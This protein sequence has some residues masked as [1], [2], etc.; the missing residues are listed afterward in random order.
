MN[1]SATKYSVD[2]QACDHFSQG[3]PA[4]VQLVVL[5]LQKHTSRLYLLLL[6]VKFNTS[7]Q[8]RILQYLAVNAGRV[9]P[10]LPYRTN[11]APPFLLVVRSVKVRRR[12]RARIPVEKQRV[13][14]M[15]ACF[16]KEDHSSRYG[17]VN[18]LLYTEASFEYS[19]CDSHCRLGF[20]TVAVD[21]SSDSGSHFT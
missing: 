3:A 9:S 19:L 21:S 10:R 14:T 16:N 2:Y 20:A 13:W 6:S 12:G 8:E 4:C 11:A 18:A 17:C 5:V 15:A 1:T 7:A